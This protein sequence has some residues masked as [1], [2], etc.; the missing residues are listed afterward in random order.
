MTAL[1]VRTTGPQNEATAW[2]RGVF[3]TLRRRLA[4]GSLRCCSHRSPM[5]FVLLWRPD[6][7]MC[8][9]CLAAEPPLPAD[10]D[11]RCDR[12]GTVPPEGSTPMSAMSGELTLLYALCPHCLRAEAVVR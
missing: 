10:E 6:R 9:P 11:Q 2:F 5:S 8:G 12:C 4:N 7:A 3:N 1:P